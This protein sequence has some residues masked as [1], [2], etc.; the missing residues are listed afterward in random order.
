MLVEVARAGDFAVTSSRDAARISMVLSAYADPE[1]S[2]LDELPA[3]DDERTAALYT[4]L[5]DVCP[6]CA[7]RR[8]VPRRCG[9]TEDAT[10]SASEA[11]VASGAVTITEMPDL[12]L[13]VID[14]GRT[15]PDGG[16]HRFGGQ[17][18]SG[19]HPIAVHT[20]TE[21][22]ALL[23]MRGSHYEL[24]YRYESWVQ[25]RTRPCGP[26]STSHRWPSG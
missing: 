5:L 19:L 23:T 14:V 13:A 22:G 21:R 25:F 2:P 26:G 6:S 15:A 3:D 18:V 17:W 10:L 24:A 16:G 4:E 7:T 12:D 9:R 20:A 1:R 8:V 11:A